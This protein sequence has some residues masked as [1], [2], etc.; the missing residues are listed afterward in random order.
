MDS[1]NLKALDKD[2]MEKFISEASPRDLSKIWQASLETIWYWMGSTSAQLVD[3]IISRIPE[4]QNFIDFSIIRQRLSKH[5]QKD[6]FLTPMTKTEFEDFFPELVEVRDKFCEAFILV[7]KGIE[8][9][10]AWLFYSAINAG[11]DA[12]LEA[13]I[14]FKS[15]GEEL[16]TPE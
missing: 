14:Y 5:P 4:L 8:K 10:E 16:Q 13:T 2:K 15:Q 12:S 9:A 7:P 6:S 11:A 1:R 3:K